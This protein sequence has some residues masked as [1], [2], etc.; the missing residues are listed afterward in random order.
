MRI[1]SIKQFSKVQR[2]LASEAGKTKNIAVVCCGPGC[3]A[4]GA[5]EILKTFDA[6]DQ[7]APIFHTGPSW[8]ADG[9][10]IATTVLMAERG[11]ESR[12][13]AVDVTTGE[14][15]WTAEHRWPW[16]AMVAWMCSEESNFT[17]G[18]VFDLSGGRATY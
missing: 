15:V 1:E 6:P 17:T 13:V 10:L 14:T 2:S 18:A 8:S 3:L 12:L 16:A 11:R 4:N 7:I 9:K 5:A